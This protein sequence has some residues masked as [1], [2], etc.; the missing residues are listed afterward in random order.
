VSCLNNPG[1]QHHHAHGT[2]DAD[3]LLSFAQFERE[4][5]GERIRA[6]VLRDLIA[7]LGANSTAY[8]QIPYSIEQGIFSMKQRILSGEQ[9]IWLPLGNARRAP[10]D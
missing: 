3:V 7:V 9:E 8:S 2:V 6:L 1:I 4:V 10:N 5:T